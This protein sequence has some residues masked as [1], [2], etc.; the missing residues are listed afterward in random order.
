MKH[1]ALYLKHRSIL[2]RAF[3]RVSAPDGVEHAAECMFHLNRLALNLPKRNL[4]KWAIYALKTPFL[5]VLY[6]QGYCVWATLEQQD[7]ECWECGGKGSFGY[8]EGLDGDFTCED[9]NGSGVYRSHQ[10]YHFTFSVNGKR[11][12]WHQP[13]DQVKWNVRLT[14]D[15]IGKY[16]YADPGPWDSVPSDE[17]V[18]KVAAA[19]YAYC[20]RNGVQAGDLPLA[21]SLSR[22]VRNEW[23]NLYDGWHSR[24]GHWRWHW[25]QLRDRAICRVFGHKVAPNVRCPDGTVYCDRCYRWGPWAQPEQSL[26]F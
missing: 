10:L 17:S 23:G 20:R 12:N 11:Y 2:R 15:E 7:M 6:E 5:R 22:A 18:D 19:V 8:D 9:C 3:R 13:A 21:P 1:L 26:P 16:T 14:T 24:I 4:R 25:R